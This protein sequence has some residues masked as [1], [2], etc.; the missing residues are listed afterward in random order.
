MNGKTLV[1]D[2]AYLSFLD[3]LAKLSELAVRV[4]E[5]LLLLAPAK[6]ESYLR[7]MQETTRA[8][9]ES[10]SGKGMVFANA[11]EAIEDL[12]RLQK[13]HARKKTTTV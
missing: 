7:L 4:R 5:K 1:Q 8:I 11:Q 9:E 12:H 13:E 10:K 3:D 2:T 6:D